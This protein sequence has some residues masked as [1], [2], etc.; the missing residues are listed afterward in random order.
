MMAN[1]PIPYVPA[2]DIE[3][4]VSMDEKELFLDEAAEKQYVLLFEHDAVNECCTVKK[5]EKG[6]TADQTFYLKDIKP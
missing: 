2:V 3:P 6:V 5:T 1:I 4:L